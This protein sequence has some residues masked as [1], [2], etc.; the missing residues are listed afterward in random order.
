MIPQNKSFAWLE[1]NKNKFLG[2][3]ISKDH[4]ESQYEI[5]AEVVFESANN[6]QE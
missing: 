3:G 5:R 1:S 2:I 6:R 4:G